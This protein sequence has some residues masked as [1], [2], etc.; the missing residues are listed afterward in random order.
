MAS[1]IQI[2]LALL[3]PIVVYAAAVK[4]KRFIR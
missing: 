2:V 1:S 4:L 3:M